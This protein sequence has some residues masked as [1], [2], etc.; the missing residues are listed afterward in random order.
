MLSLG[1]GTRKVYLAVGAN[2]LRKGFE[3]LYGL[4]RS[5]LE[6]DPLSRQLFVFC[7]AARTRVRPSS[8]TV[9][10]YGFMRSGLSV[11]GLTGRRSGRCFESG[12][13][14]KR[15]RDADGR[16]ETHPN[17][18]KAV[19]ATISGAS[20]GKLLPSK[21]SCL[22]LIAKHNILAMALRPAT[23]AGWSCFACTPNSA[24][25]IGLRY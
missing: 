16:A 2:N 13:Q 6:E 20:C 7:N 22:L 14:R 18:G 17:A 11:V 4:V 5:R 12:R 3:G 10:A 19:V 1:G 9:V 25:I 15:V 21:V 23:Q 8:L 24:M